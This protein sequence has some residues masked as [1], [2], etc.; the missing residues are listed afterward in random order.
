MGKRRKDLFRAQ[1]VDEARSD[2]AREV[3]EDIGIPSGQSAELFGPKAEQLA[4]PDGVEVERRW[5]TAE[6]EALA[7]ARA[8]EELEHDATLVLVVDVGSAQPSVSDQDER[9]PGLTAVHDSM[10][11]GDADRLEFR[12]QTL[13][14]L[15]IQPTTDRSI[16]EKT[17]VLDRRRGLR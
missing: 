8:P 14:C 5:P 7:H 11:T 2:E 16:P 4:V 17:V 13:E 1:R 9:R 10:A 15:R 6:D 3:K 12:P